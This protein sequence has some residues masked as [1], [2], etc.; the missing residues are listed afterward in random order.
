MAG[1]VKVYEPYDPK[2]ER[3]AG[4][5]REVAR[6]LSKLCNRSITV[7]EVADLLNRRQAPMCANQP[8]LLTDPG[9]TGKTTLSLWFASHVLG[10][11]TLYI[12]TPFCDAGNLLHMHSL[13]QSYKLAGI[14]PVLVFDEVDGL[15]GSP[16]EHYGVGML[17]GYLEDE[18][19]T[20]L[21]ITNYPKTVFSWTEIA[22]RLKQRGVVFVMYRF[23]GAGYVDVI[24][25]A[26]KKV[27]I[28]IKVDEE[29]LLRLAEQLAAEGANYHN[30]VEAMKILKEAGQDVVTDIK[31]LRQAFGE[32]HKKKGFVL[33]PQRLEIWINDLHTLG[34]DGRTILEEAVR[35]FLT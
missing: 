17:R 33:S 5:M 32:V 15:A 34:E 2:V 8:V 30:A 6:L 23:D 18:D 10:R 1:C 7:E 12:F 35:V 21:L 20:V 4:R 22:G 9:R 25:T 27:G 16:F 31:A 11:V 24:Q 14:P 19:L 3:P 26:A 29:E 28:E 13:V